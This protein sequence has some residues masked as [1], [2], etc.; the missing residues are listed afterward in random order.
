M[1]TNTEVF[2]WW[3]DGMGS[4]RSADAVVQEWCSGG[5]I[6]G[7]FGTL[8]ADLSSPCYTHRAVIVEFCWVL[9]R[10]RTIIM[11]KQQSA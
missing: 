5:G 1:L 6:A 3:L 11:F 9:T 8:A 10:S 4:F 7:N 2:N